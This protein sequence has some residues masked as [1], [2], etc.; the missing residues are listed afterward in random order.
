M[1]LSIIG[2]N[3]GKFLCKDGLFQPQLKDEIWK[4][5]PF[6]YPLYPC[7]TSSKYDHCDLSQC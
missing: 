2:I 4:E 7:E 6:C 3:V 5:E 1:I